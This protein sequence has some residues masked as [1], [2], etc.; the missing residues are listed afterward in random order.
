MFLFVPVPISHIVALVGDPTYLPCDISTTHEGDSVHL[1][2]W[3]REDLGTSVYSVDARDRDFGIA[4]RWSDDT[5]FSNRAYFM[6]DKKP[7]ELGVDHIREEDAGIY[8]CRVDFQI[9]Q[10]RNSKVNL[11][12]IGIPELCADWPIWRKFELP[13]KNGG[14]FEEQLLSVAKFS[15]TESC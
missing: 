7:A 3:Y 9:G 15:T 10:T 11:T 8:R 5:V 12:V 14:R 2:L 6:P 1:V 4:E 13:E